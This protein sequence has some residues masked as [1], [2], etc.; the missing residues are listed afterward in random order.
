MEVYFPDLVT[1]ETR[2]PG[3]SNPQSG[4]KVV[5]DPGI[6]YTHQLIDTRRGTTDAVPYSIVVSNNRVYV[7]KYYGVLMM[8][9]Y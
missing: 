7:K 8:N 6:Y 1:H 2:F 3:N 5:T 4:T 9:Q